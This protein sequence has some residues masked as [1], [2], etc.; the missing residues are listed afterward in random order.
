LGI[1]ARQ[2]RFEIRVFLL[3][4]ELSFQTNKP[5]LPKALVLRCLSVEA[6]PP[7]IYLCYTNRIGIKVGCQRLFVSLPDTDYMYL[8]SKI[9]ID[10][11][12]DYSTSCS[13]L[14]RVMFST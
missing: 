12:E 5:H 7:S 1:V 6:G 2:R 8:Y 13:L 14:K 10:S 9:K 11:A 4:D 3:L